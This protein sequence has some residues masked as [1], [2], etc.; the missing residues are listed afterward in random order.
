[1]AKYAKEI[2]ISN[3]VLEMGSARLVQEL[4]ALVGIEVVKVP[5][6]KPGLFLDLSRVLQVKV[7]TNS[8][9]EVNPLEYWRPDKLDSHLK[10][11]YVFN[12]IKVVNG[13]EIKRISFSTDGKY[14]VA[15]S[16][17]IDASVFCKATELPAHNICAIT[18][19]LKANEFPGHPG[20]SST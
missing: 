6:H 2:T 11:L 5:Y 18:L 10:A 9:T 19:L 1:M 8:I 17:C 20:S 4:A 16:P 15:Y 3:M 12:N 7:P 14:S 13:I